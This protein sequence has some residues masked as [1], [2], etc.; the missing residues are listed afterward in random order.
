M[1]IMKVKHNPYSLY[2]MMADNSPSVFVINTSDQLNQIDEGKPVLGDIHIPIKTKT[3]ESVL[4]LVPATWIPIDLSLF[5]DKA[6]IQ[7]AAR[8][9]HM[10]RTKQIELI[11]PEEAEKVLAT[12]DAQKEQ[13]YLN[14]TSRVQFTTDV[15]AGNLTNK[16]RDN[17]IS[18]A[19]GE[20]EKVN[21]S[22]FVADIIGRDDLSD[23]DRYAMLNT[24]A[25]SLTKEDWNYVLEYSNSEEVKE[26]ALKHCVD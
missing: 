21:V 15:M 26:L 11:S 14:K 7:Q 16:E 20:V 19:K 17:G 12:K 9:R 10:L 6:D 23:D 8:F 4:L 24:K 22:P 18:L 3:G 25:D 13:E 5:A 2:Q 1:K